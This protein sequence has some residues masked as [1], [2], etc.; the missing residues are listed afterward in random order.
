MVRKNSILFLLLVSLMLCGLGAKCFADAAAQFEQAEK[1]EDED[2]FEQAEAIYKGIAKDY[3]GKEDGLK[4]QQELACLYVEAGRTAEAETAY[5]ELLAGYGDDS[6]IA[7]AVDDVANAYRDVKKYDKALEIYSYLVDTW[8]DS[9]QA[10]ES[11]E[12]VAKLYIELGDDPNAE[13]AVDKLIAG[14]VD[15]DDI[16]DAVRHVADEY[17]EVKKYEKALQFY[18]QV[19]DSWPENEKAMLSQVSIATLYIELGDDPNAEAAVDKLIAEFADRDDIADAVDD[20]ADEYRDIKN[21]E[22]A[23]GLYKCVVDT[24]PENEKAMLSQV[25]ITKLNIK[26]N[27]IS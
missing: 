9:E 7:E 20:V 24:W 13:A 27:D 18:R 26:L 6:G 23:L 25:S 5:K 8:G 11:Q 14:F 21:Y 4:A 22:K 3:A 1:Y 10:M 17:R 16:A 12:T 2:N 15:R 19:V